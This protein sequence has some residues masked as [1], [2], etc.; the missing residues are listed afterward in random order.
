M[1]LLAGEYHR[2][3]MKWKAFVVRKMI[4]NR[5]AHLGHF[6][7]AIKEKHVGRK[8]DVVSRWAFFLL[9]KSVGKEWATLGN[10]LQRLKH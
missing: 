8:I 10:V 2:L 3:V 6:L 4:G 7:K 5:W 1:V 9:R